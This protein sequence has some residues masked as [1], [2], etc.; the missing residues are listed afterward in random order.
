MEIGKGVSSVVHLGLY[1]PTLR[2]VAV[3]EMQIPQEEDQKRL[4]EEMQAIHRNLVPI[5]KDKQSQWNFNH[6]KAIGEVHPCPFLV[7]YYGA[8]PSDDLIKVNLVLE[9]MDSGTLERVIK[10][11]GVQS[12]I[13]LQRVAYCVLKGLQH[14]RNH[15]TVH[16]DIK[17]DNLLI[18]HRGNIKIADLGVAKK[19]SKDNNVKL[20]DRAGTVSYYSPE[21]IEGEPYAFAAVG[22]F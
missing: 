22:H 1:V 6:Y 21:R 14:L 11:G 18:D 10:S 12:E 9:Y 4:M 19:V 15:N 8:W 5:A 13:I 17:P 7:G 16:R 2:L 3:K 20:T